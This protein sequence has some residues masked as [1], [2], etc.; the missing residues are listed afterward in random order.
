MILFI[1]MHFFAKLVG[2]NECFVAEIPTI[3]TESIVFPEIL[4]HI[5]VD[6]PVGEVRLDQLHFLE[7][8]EQFGR[9]HV[10]V[11]FLQW[12]GEAGEEVV[13][14]VVRDPVD[15]DTVVEDAA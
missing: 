8:T 15:A 9:G 1:L 12:G 6:F 11:G 3:L 10:C 7:G 13:S 4:L 5:P 14:G 2:M